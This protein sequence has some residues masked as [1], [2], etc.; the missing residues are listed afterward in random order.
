[1]TQYT[2]TYIYPKKKGTTEIMGNNNYLTN[3]FYSLLFY[4]MLHSI[5]LV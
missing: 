4:S 2:H 5:L 3:M 1:M